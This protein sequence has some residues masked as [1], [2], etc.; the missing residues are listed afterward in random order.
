MRPLSLYVNILVWNLAWAKSNCPHDP[1]N[2]TWSLVDC[3]KIQLV[4]EGNS[5]L[6]PNPGPFSPPSPLPR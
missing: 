6:P 1:T 3:Q 2:G 4:Y 5:L